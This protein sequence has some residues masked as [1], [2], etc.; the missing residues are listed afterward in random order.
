MF[1]CVALLLLLAAP[2]A[3]LAPVSSPRHGCCSDLSHFRRQRR[4]RSFAARPLL[5]ATATEND[6]DSDGGGGGVRPLPPELKP[7]TMAVFSQMLGEGIALSSLPLYLTRLGASPLT[8]GLAI[9]CFS[10]MQVLKKLCA[11]NSTASVLL[12][13]PEPH[14]ATL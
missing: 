12:C 7:Y 9:S 11:D 5:A 14:L 3:A 8:V 4:P 6:D 1:S 10:V 2:S 13:V